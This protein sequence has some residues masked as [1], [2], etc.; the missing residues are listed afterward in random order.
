MNKNNAVI[1]PLDF[2]N[3]S[4][5]SDISAAAE[6]ICASFATVAKEF[7]ITEQNFPNH[8][9]FI[10]I[11]KLQNHFNWGWQMYGLYD[12]AHL[13]GYVSL[14]KTVGDAF[15]LHNLAVLPEYRHKGY[16]RLLLDF[17]KTKVIESCRS[18]IVLS[19]IE[20]NTVLKDWYIANGFIHTGMK[21]FKHM[22]FTV[23]F[24][25]WER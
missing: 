24:M 5:L 7:G 13:I 15:E 3:L 10:S 23:G 16:G 1:K 18:K 25:E 12:G 4:D 20:E 6:V 21:W 9:S 17:C 22:P 14:S 11:E 19:I 8:M 2:S